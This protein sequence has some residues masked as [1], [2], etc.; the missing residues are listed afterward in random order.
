MYH[1]RQRK[2]P[3]FG[4]KKKK[5]GKKNFLKLFLKQNYYEA[6]RQKNIFI[7]RDVITL[8]LFIKRKLTLWLH[9][10]NFT[11]ATRMFPMY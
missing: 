11:T 2:Q 1:M 4:K 7:T 5:Q 8:N 3:Y 9:N 6:E 10:G